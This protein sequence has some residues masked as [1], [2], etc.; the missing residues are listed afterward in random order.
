MKCQYCG[1]HSGT[2][3]I[4]SYEC[5]QKLCDLLEEEDSHAPIITLGDF[6]FT[7]MNEHDPRLLREWII[8]FEKKY[9]YKE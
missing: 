7:K 8:E 6:V 3:M 4:C 9:A 1:K 5:E 2:V